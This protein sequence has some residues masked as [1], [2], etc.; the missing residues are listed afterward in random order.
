M[1]A[2]MRDLQAEKN[3]RYF[4]PLGEPD[5]RECWSVIGSVIVA[6]ARVHSCISGGF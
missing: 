6:S 2:K 4:G 1:Y 3:R 5:L